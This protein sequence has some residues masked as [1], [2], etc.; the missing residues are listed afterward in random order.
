MEGMG[1]GRR[2]Y[3]AT[4]GA[5]EVAAEREGVDKREEGEAR[6]GEGSEVRIHTQRH[7]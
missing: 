3:E 4:E 6:S 2:D 7:K 5:L 1:K